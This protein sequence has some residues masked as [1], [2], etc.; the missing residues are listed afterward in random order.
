ME[1]YIN[2]LYRGHLSRLS[3]LTC[4]GANSPLKSRKIICSDGSILGLYSTS[5]STSTILI[6][7]LMLN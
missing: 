2:L 7:I 6:L 5:T 3:A 1:N 4:D